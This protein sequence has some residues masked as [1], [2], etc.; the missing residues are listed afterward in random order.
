MAMLEDVFVPIY[1]FHRYQIEAVSKVVGGLYYS[2]AVK[3]D[4]QM[5][6]RS[7][8]KE[9]QLNALNAITDCIDPKCWKYRKTY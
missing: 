4:G 9:E 3:G 6:T 8:T 2:Y 7:V 5:I 1:L